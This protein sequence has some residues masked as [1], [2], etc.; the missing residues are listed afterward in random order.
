MSKVRYLNIGHID[1]ERDP[2]MIYKKD[3]EK[4][5]HQKSTNSFPI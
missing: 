1:S 4:V 3:Q 2:S 5:L